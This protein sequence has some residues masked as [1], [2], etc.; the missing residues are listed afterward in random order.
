MNDKWKKNDGTSEALVP[1]K[2]TKLEH[3]KSVIRWKF[4]L[5]LAHLCE[6]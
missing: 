4:N 1:Q 6:N 2:L 3:L 5:I